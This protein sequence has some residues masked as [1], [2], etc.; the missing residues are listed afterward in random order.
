MRGLTGEETACLRRWLSAAPCVGGV[1]PSVV[2]GPSAEVVMER[3]LSRG[4]LDQNDCSRD[5]GYAH[6]RPNAEA[7]VALLANDAASGVFT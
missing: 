7:K 1:C 6:F 3:L 4:L 5:E 2:M